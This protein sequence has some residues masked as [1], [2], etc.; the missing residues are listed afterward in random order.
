M[1]Y[2]YLAKLRPN[3]FLATSYW[4]L[5]PL[6]T[7]I[8]P[9]IYALN[10]RPFANFISVRIRPEDISGTIS[11]IEK[12]WHSFT[13]ERPFEYSFLDD[14]LAA[15]Y[16]AEQK[17]RQISAIF[18]GIAILIGCLGLFGLA[19][20]TAEQRIK[21]IGV[22]KVL[23]ASTSHIMYLL[24]REF[25]KLV[26]GCDDDDELIEKMKAYLSEKSS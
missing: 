2:T 16:A 22:R 6:H 24:I 1:K 11:G 19:A 25:T 14:D 26:A 5:V 7:E 4:L 17:T 3:W 21:E 15:Q 8:S 12:S 9:V 10:P 13:G 20:F 23:G 18:S